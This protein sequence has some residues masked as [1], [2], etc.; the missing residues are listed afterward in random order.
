MNDD[1]RCTTNRKRPEVSMLS[2]VVFPVRQWDAER[3][4]KWGIRPPP[5]ILPDDVGLLLPQFQIS[6]D[7]KNWGSLVITMP[8]YRLDYR[9]RSPTEENDFSSSLCVL[10]SSEA[11]PAFYPMG[12]GG[13]FGLGIKHGLGVTHTTHP[14]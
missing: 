11:Y 2:H 4:V 9:V 1:F 8:D 12:T 3:G 10:T 13:P 7:I 14:F 6:F 5:N